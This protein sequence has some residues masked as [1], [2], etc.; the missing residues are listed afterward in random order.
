MENGFANSDRSGTC[1]GLHN[2]ANFDL[3]TAKNWTGLSTDRTSGYHTGLYH[4]LYTVSQKKH[5]TKLLFM[6]SPNIDRF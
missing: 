4:A 5:A 1:V 2:L 3:Q 6:Y